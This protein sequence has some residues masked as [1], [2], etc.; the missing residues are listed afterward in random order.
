[1]IQSSHSRH[2]FGGR[3][4]CL[5]NDKWINSDLLAVKALCLEIH[6]GIGPD[7]LVHFSLLFFFLM[8]GLGPQFGKGNGG[9]R[10]GGRH[11]F[12]LAKCLIF[13]FHRHCHTKKKEKKKFIFWL[14]V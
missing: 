10:R 4:E 3:F 13:F 7:I 2:H 9:W 8:S 6:A 1:M 14:W 11:F 5:E 12:S